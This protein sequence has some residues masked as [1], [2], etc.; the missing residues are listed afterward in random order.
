MYVKRV[1]NIFQTFLKQFPNI[2]KNF[3]LWS[4][5]KNTRSRK[6]R[7]RLGNPVC[8]QHFTHLVQLLVMFRF[9]LAA[10]AASSSARFLASSCAARK[11]WLASLISLVASSFTPIHSL[12]LIPLTVHALSTK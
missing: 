10:S 9:H 5:K 6:K 12:K 2:F 8:R 4:R 1:K 3:V 11:R 7:E